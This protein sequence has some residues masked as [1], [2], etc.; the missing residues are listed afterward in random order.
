M[1]YQG[2]TLEQVEQV[3]EGDSVILESYG[4]L[5]V[6]SKIF[7]PL[8]SHEEKEIRKSFLVRTEAGINQ[9]LFIGTKDRKNLRFALTSL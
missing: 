9:L 6:A 2:L 8:R 4:T 1:N 5:K 7:S 3:K